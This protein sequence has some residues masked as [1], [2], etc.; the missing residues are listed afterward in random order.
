MGDGDPTSTGELD[1]CNY[2][3]ENTKYANDASSI[4]GHWL[5]TSYSS[6]GFTSWILN[7]SYSSMITS[8]VSTTGNFGVRP[9]IE[10]PKSNILY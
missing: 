5:E 3:L 7:G 10:V 4:Y 6:G 2:L 8:G 1:I 9:V